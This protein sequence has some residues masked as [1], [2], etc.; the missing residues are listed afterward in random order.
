MNYDCLP[1]EKKE[2]KKTDF[3]RMKENNKVPD[4][5]ATKDAIDS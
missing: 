2:E 5:S 3:D 1:A 4:A